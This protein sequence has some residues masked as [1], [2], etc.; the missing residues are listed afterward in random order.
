[1]EDRRGTSLRATGSITSTPDGTT[2]P[3]G[4]ACSLLTCR[5]GV[6]T[7]GDVLVGPYESYASDAMGVATKLG[8]DAPVTGV[9][10]GGVTTSFDGKMRLPEASARMAMSTPVSGVC[11]D[12]RI[13]GRV[14]DAGEVRATCICPTA[15]GGM[16]DVRGGI[17]TP[18]VSVGGVRLTGEG[19]VLPLT[20]ALPSGGPDGSVCLT[21][22]G[23]HVRMNGV[24]RLAC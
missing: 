9:T 15:A 18:M 22:A 19:L 2:I 24:W 14:V 11:A 21:H 10:A 12:G 16:V 6:V 20:P 4:V 7:S 23:L 1:M 5:G 13:F 17:V 3:G 8:S